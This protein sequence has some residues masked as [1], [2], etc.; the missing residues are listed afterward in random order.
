MKLV[1]P[2]RT[3]SGDTS[4]RSGWF[5]VRLH[6]DAF[7]LSSRIAFPVCVLQCVPSPLPPSLS[8][9]WDSISLDPW[10]QTG[11]KP[12]PSAPGVLE[13]K[14]SSFPPYIRT[15]I[16]LDKEN[17]L[18]APYLPSATSSSVPRSQSHQGLWPS[19][20]NFRRDIV[21][22]ITIVCIFFSHFDADH[23]L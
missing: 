6:G 23:C 1:R 9:F 12:L 10:S 22:S 2:R 11:G 16:P 20:T 3:S 7:L 15:P 21:L 13:L 17:T 14:S 5:L 19:H 4:P 8:A 18:M